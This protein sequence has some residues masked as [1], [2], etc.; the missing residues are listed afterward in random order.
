VSVGLIDFCIGYT[1]HVSLLPWDWCPHL[2]PDGSAMVYL[3]YP[4]GVPAHPADLPVE[5]VVCGP[6]GSGERARI[7]PSGGQGTININCGRSATL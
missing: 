7:A 4:P 2:A 5:L 6:D 1:G 3:S